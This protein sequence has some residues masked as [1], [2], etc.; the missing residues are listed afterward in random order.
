MRWRVFL[1]TSGRVVHIG[2]RTR[3]TSDWLMRSTLMSPI[4]G[5]AC[6]SSDA[7]QFAACRSLRHR[8]R[9]ASCTDFAASRNVGTRARRFSAR[10]S[11]PP[12]T[13]ARCSR[14]FLRASAR[15]TSGQPPKPI[16]R[17]RLSTVRRKTQHLAPDS[18]T[19]RNSPCPSWCF[20]GPAFLTSAAVSNGILSPNLSPTFWGIARKLLTTAYHHQSTTIVDKLGKYG[21]NGVNWQQPKTPRS[22]PY[23]IRTRVTRLRIWRPRPLDER[24]RNAAAY[25]L[26]S[27]RGYL[28]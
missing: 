15:L 14:V 22:T 5:K 1:A 4:S 3:R 27:I 21:T 11:R 13:A 8:G 26:L 2:V 28:E 10:M 20:P 12:A 7:H 25:R 9:C 19:L 24:G 18:Y 6:F 23:G 16:S 17:R